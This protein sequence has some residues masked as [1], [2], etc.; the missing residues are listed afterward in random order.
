MPIKLRSYF[1]KHLGEFLR[2]AAVLLFVFGMILDEHRVHTLV[3]GLVLGYI[4][5]L[6]FFIG[7]LCELKEDK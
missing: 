2:E 4:I 3:Y 7:S 6:F 5:V 1:R